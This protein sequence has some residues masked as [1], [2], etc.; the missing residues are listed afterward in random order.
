MKPFDPA[1]LENLQDARLI[2]VTNIKNAQ[3]QERRAVSA[4]LATM[5]AVPEFTHKILKP[6]GAFKGSLSTYTEPS[7]VE[8]EVRLTPDGLIVVQRG[9]KIWTALLEVKTGHNKLQDDQI[10]AYHKLAK[11]HGINHLITISNQMVARTDFLPYHV[12]KRT[13]R[14]VPVSHLSWWHILTTAILECK[15]RGIS[16]PDQ[17]WILNELIRYLTHENSGVSGL[18]DMGKY[19]TAAQEAARKETLRK[20]DPSV[21]PV[22][23]KWR[24][25]VNHI[26]LIMT[27]EL[28]EE[29]QQFS[30]RGMSYEDIVKSVGKELGENSHLESELVIPHAPSKLNI[31]VNLH[32]RRAVASIRILA[33]KEGRPLTKINWI[34]RQLR[35]APE[36]TRIEVH[37]AGTRDTSSL[38][39]KEA[40]ANP[41]L[42]LHPGDKDPRLFVI[43]LGRKMGLKKGKGPGSFIYETTKLVV[44]F[45]RDV[46]QGIKAWVPRAPQMS[47]DKS[48]MNREEKILV[49]G[50]GEPSKAVLPEN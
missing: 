19:W 12:D 2:P 21:L 49:C 6:L 5:F 17:A 33:P 48:A 1:L 8:D 31:N 10:A 18:V 35:E 28:G 14:A 47:S 34:L 24:E 9:K 25:L 42:L 36:D 4:L 45:Y 3:E 13:L 30:A 40:L 39:I 11:Q 20:N 50:V 7:F 15:Y 29:V 26:A 43:A 44:D 46:A 16:D 23:G 38:L 32:S 27:Q 41:K 37:F 22:A